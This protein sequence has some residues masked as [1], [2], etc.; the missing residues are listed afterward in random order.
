MPAPRPVALLAQGGSPVLTPLSPAGESDA[1]ATNRSAAIPPAALPSRTT[2]AEPSKPSASLPSLSMPATTPPPELPQNY[3]PLINTRPAKP[4]EL[5]PASPPHEDFSTAED[6]SAGEVS[7]AAED[8]DAT[9]DSDAA[10]NFD[11]A[12]S[13]IDRDNTGHTS[14][15]A[16]T[17]APALYSTPPAS[18]PAETAAKPEPLFSDEITRLPPVKDEP[19]A[20]VPAPLSG[21][22]VTSP[23]TAGAARQAPAPISTAPKSTAPKS[24][25]PK[26]TAPNFATAPLA[27][28]AATDDAATKAPALV[29][30]GP[31]TVNNF[32]PQPAATTPVRTP[33]EPRRLV[34]TPTAAS[35]LPAGMLPGVIEPVRRTLKPVAPAPVTARPAVTSQIIR[36]RIVDGDSLELLAARYLG[37]PNRKHEI[38]AMNRNVLSHPELL[39]I[40]GELLIRI[41]Q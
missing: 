18:A 22:A 11:A 15:E 1:A 7:S 21:Y 16:A 31:A 23:Q 37:D 19:A 2:A 14:E 38:F 17:R 27:D 25:A 9:E 36:H 20:A 4:A 5:E 40:N 10:E 35:A 32:A 13:L 30:V 28:A 34:A 12:R 39:P 29:P 3:Q 33:A 24:T 41:T 8:S 6:F 26:S